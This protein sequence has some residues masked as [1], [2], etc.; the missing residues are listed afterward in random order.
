[1]KTYREYCLDIL[2]DG[3]ALTCTQII[4]RLPS[5]RITGSRRLLTA[6]VSGVLRRLIKK[7]YLEYADADIKGPRGGHTYRKRRI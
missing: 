5:E 3:E 4:A 1:M 2:R 6:T 7:D